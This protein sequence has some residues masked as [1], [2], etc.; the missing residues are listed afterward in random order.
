[1]DIITEDL[2]PNEN[3]CRSKYFRALAMEYQNQNH[4]L[5]ICPQQGI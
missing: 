4:H 1:M 3:Y 2:E 5:V